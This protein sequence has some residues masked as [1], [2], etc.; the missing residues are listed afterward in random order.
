MKLEWTHLALTDRDRLFDYIEAEHP[1]A[2]VMLDERLLKQTQQLKQ[3]P[4]SGRPGR[5]AGTR[6][7]VVQ[8]T[9]YIIAYQFAADTVRILRVLH[10]AQ[11]WPMDAAQMSAFDLDAD[12]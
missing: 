9:P 12:L 10:E 4:K 1:Y 6:E 8:R 11:Q 7:L 5:V 3:F 2:A